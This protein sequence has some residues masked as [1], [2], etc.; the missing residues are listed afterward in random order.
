MRRRFW[1]QLVEK[2]SDDTNF[3]WTQLKVSDYFK[4]Q[5]RNICKLR[6]NRFSHHALSKEDPDS[7][8]H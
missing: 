8:I 6:I 2:I 3:A 4:K 1:W 7:S 5:K